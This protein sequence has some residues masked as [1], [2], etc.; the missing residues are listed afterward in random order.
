[1]N[2]FFA[3]LYHETTGQN[4]SHKS[5]KSYFLGNNQM[6]WGTVG[7]SVMLTQA[8]AITFLST[9][10]QGF[11]SGMSFVQNYLGQPI[12]LIIV[13]LFFIPVYFKSKIT[14][15]YKYLEESSNSF[16][17]YIGKNEL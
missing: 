2:F 16:L 13:C 4:Y 7:I 6:S 9:P 12:A 1:M 10:G 3:D 5:I 15:A 11:A 17:Q 8:T 14:T